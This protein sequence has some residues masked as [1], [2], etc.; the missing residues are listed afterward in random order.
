MI[1]E[2]FGQIQAQNPGKPFLVKIA[3]DLAF[4]QIEEILR[5]ASEHHLA[6]IVATNT[7]VNHQMVPAAKKQEGGLSGKPHGS[8]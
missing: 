1:G 8:N 4:E 7:T 3:P 2:L 5:L 6:G